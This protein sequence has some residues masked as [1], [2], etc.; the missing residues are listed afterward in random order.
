[1]YNL[2]LLLPLLSACLLKVNKNIGIFTTSIITVGF[3]GL[4]FLCACN[5]L[6]NV[7][8]TGETLSFFL[9]LWTWLDLELLSFQFGGFYDTL[10]A[11]MLVVVTCMSLC[12]H[13]YS[14]E[15]MKNDPHLQRFLCYLSL[16]SFGMLVLVASNNFIQLFLGWELIGLMSYLLIGFWYTRVQ[17]NK[18][19]IAAVLVNRIGDTAFAIAIFLIFRTTGSI[20][21][22]TVFLL[23]DQISSFELNVISFFLFLAAVGKSAQLGL[24]TW[25]PLAMEGPTPVSALLHSSTM[26]SKNAGPCL[27]F[28]ICGNHPNNLSPCLNPTN[29]FQSFLHGKNLNNCESYYPIK[30]QS[31]STL[32]S[33][34]TTCETKKTSTTLLNN[35]MLI[36]G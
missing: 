12:I 30:G 23:A 17:A 32:S 13:T 2:V 36:S 25:L 7:A 21:F 10:S 4:S 9:P 6:Y 11:V 29:T 31:A 5:I 1:M 35:L 15:Y 24:H 22:D 33:S 18:A 20:D 3:M 28:A 16:F 19:A 8:F 27:N 14:L 34:E 26:V